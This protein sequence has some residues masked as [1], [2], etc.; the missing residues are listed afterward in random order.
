[1]R[2]EVAKYRYRS[3]RRIDRQLAG[4]DWRWLVVGTCMSM[5]SHPAAAA[6]APAPVPVPVIAATRC[7]RRSVLRA[8]AMKMKTKIKKKKKKKEKKKKEKKEKEKKE[9]KTAVMM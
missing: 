7:C 8:A 5:G 3:R 6:V 1:L 2:E 9:K 4:V